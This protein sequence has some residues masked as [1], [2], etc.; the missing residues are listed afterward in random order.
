MEAK[1]AKMVESVLIA[2]IY[3]VLVI[4]LI[5]LCLWVAGQMGIAIPDPVV[6]V[7]WLIALLVILL[8]F[9]RAFGSSLSLGRR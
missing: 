3:V 7:I 5:W 4:G 9:W 6:K 8:I 2:L 1:E